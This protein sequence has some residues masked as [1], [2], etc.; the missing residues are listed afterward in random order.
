[1]PI[2]GRSPRARPCAKAVLALFG[3]L[4]LIALLAV[5]VVTMITAERQSPG[6][7]VV[8]RITYPKRSTMFLPSY[9]AGQGRP[10]PAGEVR[11]R[12]AKWTGT[13]AI[14]AVLGIFDY[15]VVCRLL[16]RRA[17]RRAADDGP[18][19]AGLEPERNRSELDPFS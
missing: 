2:D 12:T 11:L 10:G 7:R 16:R 17:R 19:D 14:V 3:G 15:F 18:A 1:M 4:F 6:S 8:Y 5:P 9:L 13:M